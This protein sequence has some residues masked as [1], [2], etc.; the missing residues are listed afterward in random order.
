MKKTAKQITSLLLSALFLCFLLCS[1]G[2]PSTSPVEDF[3]F[4]YENGN[5]IIT[6]Y[7]GSDLDIVVPNEIDGRPVTTIGKDAFKSYD[8]NSIILPDTLQKIDTDAF[9]Y[10]TQLKEIKIPDSVTY[11]GEA[12][13]HCE[14]L[15]T[16][17]ISDNIHELYGNFASTKWY[18]NQSDGILYLNN[19]IIGLKGDQP[20]EIKIKEGT[21]TILGSKTFC[22]MDYYESYQGTS[23]YNNITDIYIP[24]SVKYIQEKSVGYF[25]YSGI[26]HYNVPDDKI[27]IHGKKGSYAETYANDN[28]I[29]FMEE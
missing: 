28:K 18:K 7:I 8:L 13:N 6:S 12:F 2:T 9:N 4:D 5:A 22:N 20:N 10:C 27:T 15:E 1:C 25:S 23:D 16:I 26:E 11:L 17:E 21:K 3:T 14:N 29:Q 19:N 24:E